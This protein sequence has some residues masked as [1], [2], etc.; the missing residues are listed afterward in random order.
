MIQVE[1][2]FIVLTF[3]NEKDL[4]QLLESIKRQVFV[5]YKVVV[6]N[7]YY[8]EETKSLIEQIALQNSCDFIN[9]PNKGYG[10]GNNTGIKHANS[11]YDYRFLVV[12]NP[13]T[14]ILE[15]DFQSIRNMDNNIIA[16][17]IVT[18]NKAKQNPF[19]LLDNKLLDFIKYYSFKTHRYRMVYIDVIVN[20]IAQLFLKTL[21]SLNKRNYNRVYSCHGS[22]FIIGKKAI[23]KLGQLYNE[24]MFLFAEEDHLAKLAKS[25]NINIIMIHS[26]KILHKE[27]GS[28]GLITEKKWSL[29]RQSYMEYYEYWYN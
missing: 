13:D 3:R 27:D 18:L 29:I 22:F 10:A 15:F 7:S 11:N 25:R 20:K 21:N 4:I 8:D 1:L 2:V 16:P 5:P 17:D 12:C 14:E 23:E 26:L 6:V 19:R 24:K 28:M 9:V